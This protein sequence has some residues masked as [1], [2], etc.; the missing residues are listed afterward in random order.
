MCRRRSWN[1]RQTEYA[2]NL[3]LSTKKGGIFR[4]VNNDVEDCYF[5]LD[6]GNRYHT[7]VLT[8]CKSTPP[9]GKAGK[10]I[11]FKWC[12]CSVKLPIVW[13]SSANTEPA[14]RRRRVE[15]CNCSEHL[16][17]GVNE[18][19]KKWANRFSEKKNWRE[20]CSCIHSRYKTYATCGKIINTYYKKKREREGV[21]FK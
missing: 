21:S 18:L 3:I 20:T 17:N 14:Q 4:S 13:T 7:N 1:E 6:C 19:R 5:L 11:F 2:R 10:G 12:L 8:T 16:G 15:S 9:W